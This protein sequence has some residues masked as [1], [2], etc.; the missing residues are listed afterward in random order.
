MSTSYNPKEDT[1]NLTKINQ[2]SVNE[3][4]LLMKVL[5]GV[6]SDKNYSTLKKTILL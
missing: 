6:Y 2:E 3:T 4:G 1:V 5:L